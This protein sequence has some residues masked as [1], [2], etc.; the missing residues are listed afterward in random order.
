MYILTHISIPTLNDDDLNI[1][2]RKFKFDLSRSLKVKVKVIT[3]IALIAL[4]SMHD[5]HINIS[6]SLRDI[7]T[8]KPC[9][10]E[11]DLLGLSKVKFYCTKQKPMKVWG[12]EL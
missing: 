6:N 2:K 1:K 7:A 11:F 4:T 3:N 10:F 5:Y 9:K 12:C 8:R